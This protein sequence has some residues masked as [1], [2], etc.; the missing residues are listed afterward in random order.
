[1]KIQ[2]M[3]TH[4]QSWQHPL[5][6]ILANFPAV[7]RTQTINANEFQKPRTT[8]SANSIFIDVYLDG[9]SINKFI[10][11]S[12]YNRPKTSGNQISLP[13]LIRRGPW[14]Q[15]C[16]SD[17]F[18]LHKEKHFGFKELVSITQFSPITVKSIFTSDKRYKIEV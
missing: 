5:F 2:C 11:V 8:Q 9:N 4:E 12:L 17:Y 7:R 1:M 16:F 18:F 15:I 10:S 14:S 13:F 3:F 6:N